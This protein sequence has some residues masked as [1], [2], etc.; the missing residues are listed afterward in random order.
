VVHHLKAFMG[1][2]RNTVLLTGF[3][4][5]G[6]RGEALLNGADQLKIHGMYWPVRAEVAYLRGVSAH[7]DRDELIAWLAQAPRPKRAFVVHGEP[8]AQDNLRRQLEDQL[9]WDAEIPTH[10]QDV[11][12]E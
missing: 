12:L 8:V 9:G 6:T 7:A 1:D 2:A 4:A 10:G 3:Q 5:A 11:H